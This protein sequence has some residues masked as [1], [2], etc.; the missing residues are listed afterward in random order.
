LCQVGAEARDPAHGRS[1]G[2]EYGFTANGNAQAD[3]HPSANK[4]AAALQHPLADQ[5]SNADQDANAH[6]HALA[7][8]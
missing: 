4:D 8:S 7:A 3:E 6:P 5:H 2:Y 1:P